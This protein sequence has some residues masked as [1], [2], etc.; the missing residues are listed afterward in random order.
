MWRI[1]A[2]VFEAPKLFLDVLVAW[3]RTDASRIFKR[4][5]NRLARIWA[6]TGVNLCTG[7]VLEPNDR[8]KIRGRLTQR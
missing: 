7:R 6:G 2:F 4:S 5:A 8:I 1:V 3:R